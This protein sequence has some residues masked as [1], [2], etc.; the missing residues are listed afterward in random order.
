VNEYNVTDQTPLHVAI[1]QEHW[2]AVYYLLVHGADYE[3]PAADGPNLLPPSA[4]PPS[5]PPPSASHLPPLHLPPL[6]LSAFRLSAF[7]FSTF[8]LSAFRLSTFRFPPSALRL[9]STLPLLH[10][11]HPSQESDP[12]MQWPRWPEKTQGPY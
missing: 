7:R 9:P 8:R 5:A 11:P 4:P 10:L 1:G 6:R 3:A 12:Y 2:G